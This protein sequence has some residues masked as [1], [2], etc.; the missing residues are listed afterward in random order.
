MKNEIDQRPPPRPRKHPQLWQCYQMWTELMKMRQQH[1][2]RISA[3][4]RG[5]STF[6]KQLELDFI[7][8]FGRSKNKTVMFGLDDALDNARKMMIDYG[9]AT[10]PIWDWVTSIKGLKAG[11]EAAKL[12]AQIDDISRFDTVAKLWRFAGLAVFDGKAEKNKKGEKSHYNRN[13]KAICYVIGKECFVMQQTP[14]YV[15]IYYAEKKRQ[16][17]LHPEIV[18]IDGVNMYTDQHIDYRGWRKMMKQFL[19]DLWMQWRTIEGLSV[20]EPHKQ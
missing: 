3:I 15:D 11:G 5:K 12:I 14:I 18:K 10:G 20:T 1:L 2:L 13:L 19:A 6:D 9:K 17:E 8:Y 16:R 7:E 4:E